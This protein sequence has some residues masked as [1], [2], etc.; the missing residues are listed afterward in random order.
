MDLLEDIR[1]TLLHYIIKFLFTFELIDLELALQL[2]LLFNFFFS[3]SKIAFQ[4]DKEVWLLNDLQTALQLVVLLHQIYDSLVSVLNLTV[5]IAATVATCHRSS[6]TRGARSASS[7][8][9]VRASSSS[10]SATSS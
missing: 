2:L 8:T 5:R 1:F 7:D 3:S 9:T 10:S 6:H 4:V